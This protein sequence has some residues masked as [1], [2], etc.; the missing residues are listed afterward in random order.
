ML[1][2]LHAWAGNVP[3]KEA[4]FIQVANNLEQLMIADT[5]YGP[6]IVGTA[7]VNDN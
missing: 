7:E 2:Q 1:E 4:F 5:G 6:E 3:S